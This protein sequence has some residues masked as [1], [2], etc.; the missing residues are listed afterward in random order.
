VERASGINEVRMIEAWTHLRDVPL[1]SV[2][3][4]RFSRLSLSRADAIPAV[5]GGFVALR[6]GR[7]LE[8]FSLLLPGVGNLVFG[9]GEL[10]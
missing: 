2:G 7:L 3:G 1:V 5:L 10:G 6:L 9:A 4:G 8:F